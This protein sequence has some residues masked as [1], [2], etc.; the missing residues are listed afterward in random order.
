MG[1]EPALR[2][3]SG[4]TPLALI[5]L[6]LAL[7][8]PTIGWGVPRANAPE[9]AKTYATDTIL[10]LEAL[11]E[12]HNT[13]VVSKPDRNY[14]YPWLHYAIVAGVQAPY[15]VYLLASGDMSA[16]TPEYPFG[17]SDPVGALRVL[18][19]LG[20]LVSVLMAA[21][22]VVSTYWFA[23]KL[24]GHET[25]L[26]AALFGL[27]S[28]PMIFYSG[29]GNMDVPVAFW[30]AVGVAVFACI[31]K[32]GL[33]VKRWI[34]DGLLDSVI[35]QEGIDADYMSLGKESGCQFVL[36]TGYRGEK[37]MSPQTVAEAYKAGVDVFAYWDI[38]AVQIHYWAKD[39]FHR[40]D[41]LAFSANDP[42]FGGKPVFLGEV[43]PEYFNA[44]DPDAS[45]RLD[46][47]YENGYT[48]ALFWQDSPDPVGC[49]RRRR[50]YR[51]ASPDRLNR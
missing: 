30:S 43:D 40:F 23:R 6:A 39:Y 26:I 48:A 36:F 31:L 19:Y 20:R 10:P 17:L 1:Q 27:V 8:L 24:W 44:D 3:V 46:I 18:V 11:A 4:R 28:Y 29:V 41:E 7:Y 38:D 32:E 12:M 50:Q 49:S 33:D 22:I 21:G 25:G 37:A 45:E 34:R 2:F 9:R 47:I 14:G 15:L 35:C 13:F 51:L 5:A 42:V 16:P